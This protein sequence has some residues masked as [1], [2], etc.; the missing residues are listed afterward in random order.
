MNKYLFSLIMISSAL[1]ATESVDKG[2]VVIDK[3]VGPAGCEMNRK[4]I[5]AFLSQFGDSINFEQFLENFSQSYKAENV[6]EELKKILHN[7]LSQEEIEAIY[8]F[9][10]SDFFNQYQPKMQMF[11]SESAPCLCGVYMESVQPKFAKEEP[12]VE[13]SQKGVAVVEATQETWKGLLQDN[14]KVVVDVYAPWCGPCKRLAPRFEALAEKFAGEYAFLK[15]D[16]DQNASL[17]A[18]LKVRGFPTLIFYKDGVEVGRQ[19]GGVSEEQLE[20]LLHSHLD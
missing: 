10:T 8:D 17:V 9:V 3:L 1:G 7:Q 13:Q 4:A 15:L 11:V 12:R 5:E 14:K 18:E 2:Q 20:Q 19:V 6:Q 16:G